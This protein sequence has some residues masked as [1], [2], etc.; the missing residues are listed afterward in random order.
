M[1]FPCSLPKAGRLEEKV[2]YNFLWGSGADPHAPLSLE[3]TSILVKVYFLWLF[4][5]VV[6]Y[7]G[8]CG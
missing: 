5:Y 4:E 8:L 6:F 2:G 1:I 7:C 3:Q